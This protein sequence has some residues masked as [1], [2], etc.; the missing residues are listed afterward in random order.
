MIKDWFKDF[1]RIY[2]PVYRIESGKM[3]IIYAGYSSIKRNYFIRIICNS[4]SKEIYVGRRWFWQIPGFIKSQNPSLVISEISRIALKNFQK[5]DGFIL[6]EWTKMTIQIDRAMKEIRRSNGR[7]FC[8]VARRIRKYDLSCEILTGKEDLY[9][10]NVKFY[11]PYMT[12]RYREEAMITDLNL[13]WNSLSK[14]F[15]LAIREKGVMV[16]AA[17]CKESEDSIDLMVMGL[18]DG[19]DE[20]RRHGVIGAI[21]YFAIIEAEKKGLHYID[22]GGSHPFLTDGLTKYKMGFGA[23]FVTDDNSI[24]QCPGHWLGV[25]KSSPAAMDFV[26][27]NSFICLN[28]ESLVVR[29]QKNMVM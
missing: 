17:V 20:Y 5:Y 7:H 3:I 26:S 15:L 16:C 25:N 24:D 19:N 4:E 29:S 27:K 10:F 1:A 11:M 6:P 2:L 28:K 13:L 21:Y 9:L 8:D 14:P 12:K 23:E 18:L 22:V